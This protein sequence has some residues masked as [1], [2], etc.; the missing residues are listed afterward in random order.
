MKK[1]LTILAAVAM[2]CSCGSK[3]MTLT[4][5]KLNTF[6]TVVSVESVEALNEDD[7]TFFLNKAFE[8]C[9]GGTRNVVVILEEEGG[10]SEELHL[11]FYDRSDGKHIWKAER[12]YK[13]PIDN[14]RGYLEMET[15]SSPLDEG[16]W[17][18]L[19]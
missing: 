15:F 13:A 16:A 2:L 1:I 5:S 7:Y 11:T 18:G 4:P 10:W 8:L 19:E 14:G 6:T 17:I 9:Q 12:W 3:K